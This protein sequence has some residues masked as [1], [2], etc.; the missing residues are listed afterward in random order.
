MCQCSCVDSGGFYF[1]ACMSSFGRKENKEAKTDL[2]VDR[3]LCVQVCEK[4]LTLG[5][6]AAS[7]KDKK[8]KEKENKQ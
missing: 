2:R 3:H 7:E 4:T 5:F 6:E 1:S 8:R